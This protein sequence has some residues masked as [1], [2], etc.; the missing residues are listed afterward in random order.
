MS[1]TNGELTQPSELFDDPVKRRFKNLALP[2]S[3]HHVRIQSITERE[4]SDYQAVAVS[5]SG[6][7]LRT[8]KLKDANRRFIALCLVD[9]QGNRILPTKESGKL[10]DWDAG[11]TS[12]LYNECASHCKINSEDIEDSV[13]N[14]E[15][16]L[17]DS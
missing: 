5:K 15:E 9:S 6:D 8:D 2:V 11:D 13:K 14:S 4:F 17:V 12:Y 7:K 1:E 10:A 3:G 16:I